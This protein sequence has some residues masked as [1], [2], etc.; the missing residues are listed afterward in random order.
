MLALGLTGC[1]KQSAGLTKITY[2]AD[3]QLEEGDYLVV[4][5]GSTFV[6]PGFTATMAGED[7]SSQVE[8]DG[9]VDTSKSGIYTL[10]YSMVNA[11]GF[12]ATATRT[13][14]VLD[15]T[16]PVEGIW[17]ADPNSFRLYNGKSVAYGDAYE[18]LIIGKG[19]GKYYVEDL[20]AGWYC[21]RAG[22]GSAYSMESMIQVATDGSISLLSSQV[23]AWGDKADDF[24]DGVFDATNKTI[25]YKV[26]YGSSSSIVMVFNITL[27]KVEL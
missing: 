19:D 14:V 24:Q 16:D 27:N 18:F 6:D 1:E 26:T 17:A 22:Y 9:S 11:D 3:I 21:Q 23:S 2:Y 8:V 5:K 20:L 4:E 25:S 13:V 12:L 15:L 10:T 7:V